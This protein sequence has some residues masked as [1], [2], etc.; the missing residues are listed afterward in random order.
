MESQIPTRRAVLNGDDI[1][2][3]LLNS[4]Y[5]WSAADDWIFSPTYCATAMRL[6]AKFL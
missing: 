3:L 4:F 6:V 1:N 2:T 5:L